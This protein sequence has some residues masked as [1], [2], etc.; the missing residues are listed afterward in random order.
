MAVCTRNTTKITNYEYFPQVN[1]LKFDLIIKTSQEPR[2]FLLL[3]RKQS[4]NIQQYLNNPRAPARATN[5]DV[6]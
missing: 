6:T 4:I 5:L 2:K 3:Y 1:A